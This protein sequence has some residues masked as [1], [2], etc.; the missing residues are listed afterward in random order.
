ML[1]ASCS[2]V[3]WADQAILIVQE[4]SRGR[5]WRKI[6]PARSASGLQD[7]GQIAPSHECS[8]RTI[9]IENRARPRGSRRGG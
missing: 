3:Y 1:P 6:N 8:A 5:L 2:F 9:R 7:T 4:K